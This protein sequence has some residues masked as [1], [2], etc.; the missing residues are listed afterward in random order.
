[1]IVECST[2]GNPASKNASINRK[3]RIMKD[4]TVEARI[5]GKDGTLHS[6]NIN[7]A[8][9]L[10]ELVE[11]FGEQAV[12]TNARSNIVVGLQG[13]VRSKVGA[14]VPVTGKDLQT[15]V[16][17]WK[18]G[19]RAQGVSKVE[20]LKERF[21]GLSEADKAALLE[22]LGMQTAAAGNSKPAAGKP[23]AGKAQAQ[24]PAGK[25]R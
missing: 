1:M 8:E 5:G 15:A 16:D 17:E 3:A 6:V 11:Q 24:Q 19:E 7:M 4:L 14:K 25:R 23:T 18:P 13:F 9:T 12:F 20:K 10:D 21:A 2:F 22:S